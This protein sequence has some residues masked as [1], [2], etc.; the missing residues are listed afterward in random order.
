MPAP[1]G[2]SCATHLQNPPGQPGGFFHG[3]TR[4]GSPGRLQS[5][6]IQASMK[7][8]GELWPA[9]IW[10][11]PGPAP[12][13]CWSA[14]GKW[15]TPPAA[16]RCPTGPHS[17][18]AELRCP[19]CSAN[20][21]PPARSRRPAR[22]RQGHRRPLTSETTPGNKHSRPHRPGSRKN[23]HAQTWGRILPIRRVA[24]SE[25]GRA[26][27]GI[28]AHPQFTWCLPGPCCPCPNATP[29]P[30]RC[31][32]HF[33][34]RRASHP[35]GASRACSSWGWVCWLRHWLPWA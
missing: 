29:L 28:I 8:H 19:A 4:T 34:L 17:A 6:F 22:C 27:T 1:E 11:H 10:G 18:Q 9:G 16:P 25:D 23:P 5:G 14:K 12:G 21:A 3:R 2:R 15:C 26:R 33:A 32:M 7:A 30:S 35:I 13:S 24:C 31:A 20:A